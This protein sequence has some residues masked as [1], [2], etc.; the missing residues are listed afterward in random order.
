MSD[1]VWTTTMFDENYR[2]FELSF[3]GLFDYPELYK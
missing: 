1:K 2:V 3:P